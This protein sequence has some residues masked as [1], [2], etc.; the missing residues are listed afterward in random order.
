MICIRKLICTAH[1]RDDYFVLLTYESGIKYINKFFSFVQYCHKQ[2]QSIIMNPQRTCTARVTVAVLCVC[3]S[4]CLC[5][6][7]SVCLSVYKYSRTAGY[8][9]AY[10]QYQQ[11]SGFHIEGG[12]LGISPPPPPPPGFQKIMMS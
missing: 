10:E 9:A 3:V 12:C 5:V 8:E 2:K 7:V 11:L 4:V 6:C 1:P